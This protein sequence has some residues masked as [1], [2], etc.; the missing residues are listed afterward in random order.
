MP[1]VP[2]LGREPELEQLGL[3]VGPGVDPELGRK[4]ACELE[5]RWAQSCWEAYRAR[6]CLK[7]KSRYYCCYFVGEG[8]L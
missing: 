8:S 1:L 7:E 5:L 3:P 4:R 2:W 6:E